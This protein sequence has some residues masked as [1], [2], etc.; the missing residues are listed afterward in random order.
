M[1]VRSAVLFLAVCVFAS[2]SSQAQ[3]PV[4]TITNF[5]DFQRIDVSRLLAGDV[6]AE[7]GALMNFPN[8]ISCQTCFAVE[9][10]A[11]ETARRLQTWDPSP[12]SDLKVYAF[13][14]VRS[15][16]E[17]VDFELLNF[18]SSQ[19]SVRWLADKT[20]AT[21]AGKSELNLSR[22]EAKDFASCTQ[23]R[24]DPQKLTG[25]WAKLLSDRTKLFQQKGWD[26]TPPYE[27]GAESVT[28]A[29][30]IHRLLM[31]QLAVAH[32]FMPLLKK[33]GLLGNE[34]VPSLTPSYYWTLFDA[35]HHAT[36][37]LGAVYALPVG[38]RYQLADLEYY[39]SNSYYTSAT[40]YEV[41]PIQSGDKPASLVWRGDYFA[42]PMLAFTKGTERIAYGALMLQDIKKGI[43]CFQED[44]KAKQ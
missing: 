26:G 16:C 8:G 2:G 15:P 18:K 37:S 17:L 38:E 14:S 35:D 23:N 10:P 1:A 44:L 20:A 41:W 21:T 42:A 40:L 7:R 30:Q 36:I 32:E 6:L 29:S 9:L 3:K 5:S 25:C 22:D 13:H 19:H 27:M 4:E 28:P 34:T 12:H 39:V 33:V 24:P 11:E 43:R 31:E